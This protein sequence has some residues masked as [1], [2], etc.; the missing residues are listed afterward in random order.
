[1]WFFDVTL[2][3][4]RFMKNELVGLLDKWIFI[5]VVSEEPTICC[6]STTPDHVYPR[7]W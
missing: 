3:R 5:Y 2:T 1:V 7:A 4:W 6:V